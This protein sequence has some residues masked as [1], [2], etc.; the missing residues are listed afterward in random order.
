MKALSQQDLLDIV[1]RAATIEERLDKGFLPSDAQANEV[2][3]KTRLATWCQTVA[4]GDWEQFRRRLAWDSLDEDMVRRVLG[5]VRVPE[6][7]LLPA[8]VETLREAVRLA[9]SLPVDEAGASQADA[10]RLPFLAATAPFPF[11]EL[12]V[13]FV[14]LAGQRCAAQAGDASHLLCDE[15]HVALQRSLLQ[16]LTTYAAQALYLEFSIERHRAQSPLDRLLATADEQDQRTLYQAFIEQMLQGGLVNFFREY[17]VLARLLATITDLWVEATVEFLQRLVADWPDMQQLFGGEIELGRVMGVA[18]SLSD[19][20]RGR[21]RVIALTFTS[22]HKLV[23]KPKDLGT[24]EAYNRLLAWC[25]ERGGP[26][27]LQVLKVLNRSSHGWIEFVQHDSCRNREEV[28]RYYQRAGMLL[29]LIYALEGTDCH[30]ENLIASGEHPVLVDLETLLHHRPRREEEGEGAGAQLLA[31]EQL[32]HSVLRTGLLPNWQVTHEG[33]AAYDISGLGGSSEQER[34]IRAPQW[35][36]INTDRMTLE[37]APVQMQGHGP[38][39]DGV[40]L[41]L[42]EHSVD[43]IAGFQGM[44]RFL[45]AQRVALLAADS[46]LHELAGQQVRFVYRATHI[47]GTLMQQ[48]LHPRYLR[49]GIERNIHLELLGRAVLPLEGPLRDQGERT[50]WW[51]VFAAERQ[52]MLQ[53]D[54]PFFTA[55]ANSRALLVAPGQHIEVC[56]EEPSFDLVVTRL[57]SLDE[58]DLERQMALIHGALYAH[59]ARAEAR[60]PGVHSAEVDAGAD[61]AGNGSAER[62]VAQALALAEQIA[63]RAIHG[64]DGSAAW[65]VPQYLV[66]AERYQLQPMG[67]DLYGGTCGIALFLTALE[68][69]SGGTG[70]RELALGAVQPLRQALRAYG[71]RTARDMGIGGASGLGSVIYALTYMSQWLDEPALLADAGRAASLITAERIADDQALDLFAGAAGA[72]LG[73]LALYAVSPDDVILERAITCG[74]HLLQARIESKAGWRAWPTVDGKLLTGFSHGAAGIVYALLRLYAITQD[75]E[76]FAAAQEGMAYEDSVFVPE[77]GNWPDFRAEEQPAFMTS[78]CHGAPGIALG[79][80]GGL[81]MLDGDDIRR[82]IEIA[83]QTTRAAGVQ[84]VDHLCCG[85]LGRAEVLL[86]AAS[87]LA[88]P[89]LAEVA[90]QWAWQM[91]AKAEESGTFALHPLLPRSVSSPGFFQ[92]TAGIGYELLRIAHPERLPSVLLWQ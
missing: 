47:Y 4:K 12:L 39:L 58:A 6:G 41:R 81:A 77:A 23:Y 35:T 65:I 25:N 21:R 1:A 18:P 62:L 66:Q 40:P 72:I 44:Y 70:Y 30:S 42:T 2:V 64:A 82:K 34:E 80:L 92:G 71:N 43:V 28:Q 88:R 19:P 10:G 37:D 14:L 61:L 33:R 56:F 51:S 8:W 68:Q 83:V 48:L 16:N 13:P 11:E 15:A 38:L 90:G 3:V 57:Q 50:R 69:V 29:C 49:D 73:L 59:V 78:C 54:V 55:R 5:V 86:V 53:G 20:H 75:V 32:A 74:Q 79:R 52:A 27:P 26:L 22:G 24:E 63:A 31:F 84:G 67:Y 7:T 46:P 85:S 76:V 9:A 17:T 89:D 87:R 91:V 36:H 60:M 45:L